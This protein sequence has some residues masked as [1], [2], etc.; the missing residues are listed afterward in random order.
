MVS[1]RVVWIL[2]CLF[3]AAGIA[4]AQERQSLNDAT[5]RA[6]EKN[7]AI[8]IEREAVAAADALIG[9]AQ[10]AYDGRF[11]VGLDA[12]RHTDPSATVFSGAPIGH[13]APTTTDFNWSA[14]ISQLFKSGAVLTVSS[15]VSRESTNNIYYLFRP[16]YFTSLGVDLQQPLLRNRAI[17]P[18]R[19]ALRV[20]ALD[21]DRSSAVLARQALQTVSEVEHAYWNLVAA[22]RDR[23]TRR[24]TLALADEQRRDTEVRIEARTVAASDLAQPIA[25]LERR[26]GDLFAADEAVARAE[27]ALKQLMLDDTADP[28]W[29]VELTPSD[30][31]MVTPT[32]ID[33]AAALKDAA[34]L[35]PEFA[36]FAARSSQ[37][38]A[39][40]ELARDAVKP[41][42]DLVA[43]YTMR[44]LGGGQNEGVSSFGGSSAT[45]P[46]SLSGSLGTSWD[47]MASQKFPDARVGVVFQMAVGRH[48][49]RGKLGAV[50][51]ERRQTLLA[52][53][54]I[55]QQV[56]IEV[57]NAATALETAG[58]RMQAA[59]AGLAAAETQLRAEQD[60][61]AVG[62][63]T[64][65][66]VL[67]RQNDLALAQLAETAALTDYRKALTELSRATGTLLRD[68]GIEMKP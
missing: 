21:R 20:S 37:H 46:A 45:V 59:R 1:Q 60:R 30:D 29:S 38:D 39:E 43:G 53:A 67:T 27:N 52:K 62:A 24:G 3:G 6:L 42:L 36:E 32:T 12:G 57:R 61:F 34:R 2:V 14:S 49:A 44:G 18:A 16:A 26:R 63:T 47:A 7:H 10:G 41:Q 13:V 19:T 51:A 25:E 66:F 40:I 58:G 17:D 33:L 11:R 35:R 8:R 22:R 50:Q 4:G 5:A 23:D 31:P 48:E 56:G 64:N 65:F 68:R 9:S 54:Q 55:E 28:L 15:D